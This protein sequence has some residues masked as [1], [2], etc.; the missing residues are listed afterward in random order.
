[1]HS[2][3]PPPPPPSPLPA[4]P[5][6]RCNPPP[7]TD[8]GV[9]TILLYHPQRFNQIF[10]GPDT[11]TAAGLTDKVYNLAAAVNGVVIDPNDHPKIAAAYTAWDAH[12]NNPSFANQVAQ[13]IKEML[14]IH[15]LAYPNLKYLVI[16]GDDRIIPFYRA[17]DEALKAN[18]RKYA[19]QTGSGLLP[20]TFDKRFYLT[21]DYYSGF[22][23]LGWR[24]REFYLPQ[25]ATGRLV[26]Q[27]SEIGA[28]ITA[29]MAQSSI[30]PASAL[31]TG[32]DFLKDQAAAITTTLTNRGVSPVAS[33]SNDAWNASALRPYLTALP[34]AYTLNS[35][36]SHFTHFSLFPAVESGPN[37]IF[38]ASEITASLTSYTSTLFF[39]VGCHSGLNVPDADL[40]LPHNGIDWPQAFT[41]RLATYIGNTGYGYGD[42]DL[43]SY[44]ERLSLNFVEELARGG[45]RAVGQALLDAKHR[46]Y[47]EIGGGAF[48]SYDEKI[49]NEMTLYGLPMFSV[50]FPVEDAALRP[51][52]AVWLEQT[53]AGRAQSPLA[54]AALITT[55][56]SL[57]PAYI[58]V[59]GP[60]GAYYQLSPAAGLLALP[61]RPTLPQTS[62]NIHQSGYLAHGALLLGGSF[63]DIAN[64]PLITHVITDE[65]YAATEPLFDSAAWFPVFPA[66]INRLFRLNA[67][68]LERLVVAPAQYLS[69][70]PITGT[71]RLYTALDFEIYHA[72]TDVTDFAPP[73]IWQVQLTHNASRQP[74]FRA[75]LEDAASPIQRVVVLYRRLSPLPAQTT[76]SKAELL[77]NPAA[78]LAEGPALVQPGLY[79]YFAQAVDAAGNVGLAYDHGR[80]FQSLYTLPVWF[81]LPVTRR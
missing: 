1:M 2:L 69:V 3:P 8:F 46:Y 6:R 56:L 81:W 16:V 26:E 15:G 80:P 36:N 51:A 40:S 61:F 11:I 66:A 24:G 23:P 79:E 9:E 74:V 77:Y 71:L 59:A 10:P 73:A 72:P 70:T 38:L 35:L 63:S 18:E 57:S 22:L 14:N 68:P 62:Q 60:Q 42:S 53:L 49:V 44:S 19:E 12:P 37:P 65:T 67:E 47:N 4:R 27:P 28:F 5:P 41:R 64:D 32:Y 13:S 48:S 52:A 54:P 76:W 43:I 20:N 75:S 7:A 25:W 21:D 50:I 34:D 58:P 78:A 33:L 55:S 39:S 31:V 17:R 29:F 30:T 45:S